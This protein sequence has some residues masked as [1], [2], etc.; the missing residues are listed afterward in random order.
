MMLCLVRGNAARPARGFCRGRG[1]CVAAPR[2]PAPCRAPA[3]N[4]RPRPCRAGA[5]PR[6]LS[7]DRDKVGFDLQ[8]RDR[9]ACKFDGLIDH[10]DIEICDADMLGKPGALDLAERS[11]RFRE[12]NLRVGPVD[13]QQI[14]PRH[15]EP[16]QA[17]VDRALEVAR[18]EPVEPHLGGDEESSRLTPDA[19]GRRRPRARCRT[20]APY[21]DGDSRDGAPPRP[22]RRTC[23]PSASW[24]RSPMTGIRAP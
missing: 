6:G 7:S 11:D 19:A 24:S 17:F 22:V 4:S 8:D 15:R 2:H 9:L 21:R 14:D 10:G 3:G 16:L 20:S 12:R 23:S 13:H 1:R 18:R 5:P